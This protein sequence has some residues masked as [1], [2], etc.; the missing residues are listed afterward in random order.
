MSY[1]SIDPFR[2]T[3]ADGT[4]PAGDPFVV[5]PAPCGAW[6]SLR[7]EVFYSGLQDRAI[8]CALENKLGREKIEKLLTDNGI[9]GWT[10]YPHSAEKLTA[11]AAKIR[12]MSVE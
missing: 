1:K 10:E 8:L 5:Y 11:L 7:L 9:S 3:D 2:T 4:F 12:R 6:D